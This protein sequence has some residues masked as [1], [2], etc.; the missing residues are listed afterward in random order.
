M[1]F[2]RTPLKKLQ[3]KLRKIESTIPIVSHKDRRLIKEEIKQRKSTLAREKV[4]RKL[5]AANIIE[6]PDVD[7]GLIG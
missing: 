7:G 3:E 2:G 4:E 1:N 6:D 5:H